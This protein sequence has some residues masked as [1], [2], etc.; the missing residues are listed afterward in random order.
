M[1]LPV[2]Q[3]KK[4]PNI[5]YGYEV[6]PQFIEKIETILQ[7]YP[8]Y[9]QKQ[10]E[11][12][13]LSENIFID[14]YNRM[15]EYTGLLTYYINHTSYLAAMAMFESIQHSQKNILVG[16]NIL[17]PNTGWDLVY[18]HTLHKIPPM[19]L[20]SFVDIPYCEPFGDIKLTKEQQSFIQSISKEVCDRTPTKTEAF[21]RAL[22]KK[23]PQ[24]SLYNILNGNPE[25]IYSKQISD[26]IEDNDEFKT[27]I[28][29]IL[30]KTYTK[31][32]LSDIDITEVTF[33]YKLS[34][35]E[36]IEISAEKTGTKI[37]LSCNKID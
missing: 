14:T 2:T 20:T 26:L 32:L 27:K 18:V 22:H 12:H 4:Y 15:Y 10:T 11:I 19:Y 21:E 35:T 17:M 7:L 37:Y 9:Q 1:S 8:Q 36:S 28:T 29:D 30:E 5:W 33:T 24:C 6:T 3:S 23:L 31:Y 34:Y 16:I 13:G 25:F